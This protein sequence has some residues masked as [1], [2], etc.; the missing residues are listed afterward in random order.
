MNFSYKTKYKPSNSKVKLNWKQRTVFYLG[1]R[2]KYF[3]IYKAI[4]YA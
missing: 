3:L 4:R 1:L 2:Y